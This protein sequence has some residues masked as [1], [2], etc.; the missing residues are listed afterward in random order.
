M[1]DTPVYLV[2]NIFEISDRETYGIYER[3]F[4]PLLKKHGGE[5]VSVD[6]NSESLEGENS[7]GGRMVILRFA[8]EASAKAWHTDPDYQALAEHRRAA[9]N[10]NFLQL[11]R[12]FEE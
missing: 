4:M 2:A 10:M 1:S 3:G 7:L 6:E 8:D 9:S 5:L 11:V 12:G